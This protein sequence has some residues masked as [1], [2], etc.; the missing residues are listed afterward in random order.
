MAPI[1]RRIERVTLRSPDQKV[2]ADA[3]AAIK[4]IRQFKTLS[5]YDTGISEA[6]LTDLLAHIRIQQLYLRSEVVGRGRLD[7]LNHDGLTWLSVSRTQ[8]SNP[9]IDSLPMTLR[10]L[11]AT[12]TRIND[13]GLEKFIRLTNLRRLN[14]RRTPTSQPAVEA[15]RKKMPWCEIQWELLTKP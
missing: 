15:L 10:L 4:S 12:R 1:L 7:W 3:C 2:L 8:F 6:V 13:A 9:A 11:D 5:F 14:L